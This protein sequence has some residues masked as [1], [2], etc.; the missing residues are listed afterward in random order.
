M[1]KLIYFLFV[2][3]FFLLVPS[4]VLAQNQNRDQERIQSP[5]PSTSPMGTGIKN[6]NRVQ[7]ENEGED[8]LIQTQNQ[9]EENSNGMN[10][11]SE[12][13]RQHMS[14]VAQK[15]EE[16]LADPTLT[17][18]IGEQ[19]REVAKAQNDAQQQVQEK[20]QK[21]SSRGQVY[22]FFFGPDYKSIK[23]LN[24]L[25]EQN[26]LRIIQMEELMNKLANE[27]DKSMIQETIEAL[28]QM[29]T[30]LSEMIAQEEKTFSLFG[31][32]S[33]IFSK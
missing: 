1:K 31:L 21:I 17:G 19:I 26:Q 20:F 11:R 18:G 25:M 2:F 29:N 22:K 10:S 13:A 7:T 16:L 6:Q 12:N 14:I 9:E 8:N 3:C 27:G 15:V 4:F 32:L 23:D 33:R 28:T 30:S 24:A 5:S